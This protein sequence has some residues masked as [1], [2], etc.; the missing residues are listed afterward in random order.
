MK[1]I[2]LSL[3][4]LTAAFTRAGMAPAPQYELPAYLTD[5]DEEV[6]RHAAFTVSYNKRHCVPNYVA[7]TLTAERVSGTAQ[8]GDDFHADE[9]QRKG[10]R[11]DERAY[12]GSGYDRGHMCPAGDNK[13]SRQAMYD[14]FAMTN[15]CPQT[16]RLNAGDW[17]ELEE[18]CR[19]WARHYRRLYIV[20]GPVLRKGEHYPT[21]G[22][23]VS[24]TVPRQFFKVIMRYDGRRTAEAIGFIYNNNDD[25]RPMR[26]YACTVDRVEALTGINFFSK[27][28]RDVEQRAEAR[29]RFEAW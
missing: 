21:I 6:I 10:T 29:M 23:G 27:L 2:L 24:I 16:R 20:C 9:L 5:R 1:R 28:P 15:M 12:R 17:K 26:S 13:Q 22:N 14:C 8:R 18:K 19:T 11:V 25:N 3:L 4:L 7:W